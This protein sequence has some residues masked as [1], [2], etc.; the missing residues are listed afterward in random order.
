MDEIILYKIRNSKKK[1]QKINIFTSSIFISGVKPIFCSYIKYCKNLREKKN[2]LGKNVF[3]RFEFV[4]LQW[5]I[6]H[7]YV[8]G[9]YMYIICLSLLKHFGV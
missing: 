6:I 4:G 8:Y 9:I 2:T 5:I 7:F 3:V 1:V